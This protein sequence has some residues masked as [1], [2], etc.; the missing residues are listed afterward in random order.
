MEEIKYVDEKLSDQ[1]QERLDEVTKDAKPLTNV[2]GTKVMSFEEQRDLAVDVLK[3]KGEVKARKYNPDGTIAKSK[4]ISAAINVGAFFD[5]KFRVKNKKMQV[6]TAQTH[7]GWWAI[8]EQTSGRVP[9]K[10][11]TAY[12]FERKDGVLTFVEPVKISDE[13]FITDFTHTLNQEAM[14]EV[15]NTGFLGGTHTDAEKLPI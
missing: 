4:V 15:L 12:T 5:N 9:F 3:E 7:E 14:T 13:E 2:N 8:A 11:L 6:V 10:T 1:K